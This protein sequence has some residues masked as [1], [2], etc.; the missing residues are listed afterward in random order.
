MLSRPDPA[1]G[2][3]ARAPYRGGVNRRLGCIAVVASAVA[4]R[5]AA[6]EPTQT[7]EPSPAPAIVTAQG[8]Q[9]DEQMFADES[10][11]STGFGSAEPVTLDK[12]AIKH[13]VSH[14][15]GDVRACYL[16]G[17]KVDPNLSA[18]VV[19][20]FEIG[21]EGTVLMARVWESDLPDTVAGVGPCIADAVRTW[22]FPPAPDEGTVRVTYPFRLDP[23]PPVAAQDPG[24]PPSGAWFPVP[25][26]PRHTVI[27]QLIDAEH[28]P[29]EGRRVQLQMKIGS[30]ADGIEA[31]TDERGRAR[32]EKIPAGT[33]VVGVVGPVTTDTTSTDGNAIGVVLVVEREPAP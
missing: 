3:R 14:H 28:E 15:A 11:A 2:K 4:C 19:I 18:R 23:N 31:V 8:A 12:D 17:L 21:P 10:P 33:E 6:D 26:Y 32:F 24:P 1:V 13:V 27:V 30:A 5:A 7:P 25:E 9:A 16:E 22:H 20:D 29:I